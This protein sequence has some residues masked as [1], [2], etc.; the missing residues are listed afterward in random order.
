MIFGSTLPE[1]GGVGVRRLSDGC[2]G[3]GS[4]ALAVLV[5]ITA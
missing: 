2:D 3:G 1:V 4:V 5:V